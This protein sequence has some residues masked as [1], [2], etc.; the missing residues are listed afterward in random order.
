MLWLAVLWQ[1]G[2]GN[3]ETL[4]NKVLLIEII[5]HCL[6]SLHYL[7]DR[8]KPGEKSAFLCF[9][10]ALFLFIIFFVSGPE[11]AVEAFQSLSWLQKVTDFLKALL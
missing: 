7:E 2:R 6:K 11:F 4:Y 10:N 9:F 3:R 5:W 1:A 8:Q